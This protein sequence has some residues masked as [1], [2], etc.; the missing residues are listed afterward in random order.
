[1]P[2]NL[3]KKNKGITILSVIVLA[4]CAFL[5]TGV[6]LLFH[7][8][9]PKEDGTWMSCHYAQMTVFVLGIVMTI[10]SIFA[11]FTKKYVALALRILTIACAVAAA[12]IPGNEIRLCMMDEM[13]CRAVMRPCVILFCVLII[14]F[15]VFAAMSG[16]RGD[17]S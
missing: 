2:Q 3:H 4:L 5:T 1:M 13:R 7:A 12:V 11:F 14:V 10:L 9:G 16:R 8:C 17:R 6:M 15:T